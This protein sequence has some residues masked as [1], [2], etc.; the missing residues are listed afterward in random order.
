MFRYIVV[1]KSPY[2]AEE[3]KEFDKLWRARAHMCTKVA[4]LRWGDVLY[5]WRKTE[6]DS[7]K[8]LSHNDIIYTMNE[9]AW[10]D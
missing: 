6:E 3:S 2:S 10:D 4:P 1:T 8:T 5:Q 9:E 7:W